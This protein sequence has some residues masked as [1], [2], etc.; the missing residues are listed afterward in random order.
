MATFYLL[1]YDNQSAHQ[2]SIIMGLEQWHTQE[3]Y[4]EAERESTM[5]AAP[6]TN[7]PAGPFKIRWLTPS[8]YPGGR[9]WHMEEL[10]FGPDER[11]FD[12]KIFEG[13]K[14]YW[15]QDTRTHLT[16]EATCASV[17][18]L[19]TLTFSTLANIR[20]TVRTPERSQDLC[21]H[22]RS[23]RHSRRGRSRCKNLL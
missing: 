15:N 12:R 14:V 10:T 18:L 6:P 9:V 11:I 3:Q 22:S 21:H 17:S 4:I 2:S 8:N 16:Q 13:S 23:R 1:I 19:Y 7:A 5:S 20:H